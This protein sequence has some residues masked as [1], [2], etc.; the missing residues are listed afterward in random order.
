M[1]CVY[2]VDLFFEFF[3]QFQTQGLDFLDVFSIHTAVSFFYMKMAIQIDLSNL[4]KQ[5]IGHI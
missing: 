4:G 1:D 2:V 3:V 5:I